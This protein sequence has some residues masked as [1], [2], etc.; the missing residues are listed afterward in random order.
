[1]RYRDKT[2]RRCLESTNT[3]DWDEAQQVLRGRLAA[4]DSNTLD[5]LRNGKQIVFDQWADYFLEHYSKPPIRTKAT[6]VANKAALRTLRPAFGAMKLG[7]VNR[8]RLTKP[9]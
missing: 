8:K 4:R 5:V 2:G 9:S 6:H 3:A 1:M 7:E